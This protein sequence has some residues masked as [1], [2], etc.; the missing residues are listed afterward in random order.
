ML[1]DEQVS[2]YLHSTTAVHQDLVLYISLQFRIDLPFPGNELA[3]LIIYLRGLSI[4]PITPIIVLM[5][6]LGLPNNLKDS[7]ALLKRRWFVP[8]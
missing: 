1:M 8:H 5:D 3:Y 4:P 2:Q 7:S 6:T